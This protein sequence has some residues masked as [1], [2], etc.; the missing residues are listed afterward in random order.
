MNTRKAFLKESTYKIN[1]AAIEDHK[2]LGPGLLK[3]YIINV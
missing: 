1:A 3:V 2:E